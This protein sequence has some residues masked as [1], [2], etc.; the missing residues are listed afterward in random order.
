MKRTI[1]LSE[2]AENA[3]SKKKNKSGYIS[4]LILRD[5]NALD[6][7]T[8]ETDILALIS[9]ILSKKILDTDN[10]HDREY[11]LKLLLYVKELGKI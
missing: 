4:E 10:D 5:V 1:Y 6:V 9:I 7:Q 8:K 11:V 3:I 2:E